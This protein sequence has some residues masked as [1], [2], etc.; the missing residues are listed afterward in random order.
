MNK[1]KDRIFKYFNKGNKNK[2]KNH[3]KINENNPTSIMFLN[4]AKTLRKIEENK[5]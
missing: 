5:E 2:E 4:I 1:I 3:Y